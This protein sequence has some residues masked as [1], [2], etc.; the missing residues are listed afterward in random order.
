[1]Q[2]YRVQAVGSLQAYRREMHEQRYF[3]SLRH[4]LHREEIEQIQ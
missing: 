2:E 1:M 4:F 3:S